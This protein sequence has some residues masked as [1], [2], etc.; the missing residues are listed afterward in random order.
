MTGPMTIAPA[1]AERGL[2]E[3]APPLVLALCALDT[4]V[5]PH[6]TLPLQGEGVHQPCSL[7]HGSITH[8]AQTH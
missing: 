2:G 8:H 3:G 1:P 5:H 6:P 4:V 7:Y